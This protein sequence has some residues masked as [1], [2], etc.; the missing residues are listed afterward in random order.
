M[1]GWDAK[2]VAWRRAT[3]DDRAILTAYPPGYERGEPVRGRAR[4]RSPPSTDTRPRAQTPADTR[5]THMRATHFDAAGMLR[6]SAKRAAQR[7][8]A[9]WRGVW[10]AAGMN[11]APAAAWDEASARRPAALRLVAAG[12]HELQV[13]YVRNMHGLFFGEEAA[14]SVRLWTHG[15]TVYHPPEAVAF[16]LWQRS[17]RPTFREQV[18]SAASHAS[19]V[20][21]GACRC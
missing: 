5:P 10:W 15:W 13:P 21:E 18:R 8:D 6:L 12:A 7:T 20:A 19:A 1:E 2:L 3:A 4:A 16:H 11:F 14:M 17:Y 9:A